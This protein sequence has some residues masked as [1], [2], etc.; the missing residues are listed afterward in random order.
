MIRNILLSGV[1]ANMDSSIAGLDNGLFIKAVKETFTF[2]A[3]S[4]GKTFTDSSSV[5][6]VLVIILISVAA[7][8]IAYN[9]TYRRR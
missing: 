1:T 4:F 6:Y 7:M 5:I 3:V 8:T 9:K 2:N